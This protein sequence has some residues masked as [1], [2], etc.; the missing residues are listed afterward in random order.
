MT[1]EQLT[2]GQETALKFL[3][4]HALKRG[5]LLR[6]DWWYPTDGS[7]LRI[8]LIKVL[9]SKGLVEIEDTGH[10]PRHSQAGG[11]HRVGLYS[12]TSRFKA[13]IS[14]KHYTELKKMLPSVI[15]EHK[16]IRA[17]DFATARRLGLV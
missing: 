17:E 14:P 2:S 5:W 6:G 16:R 11:V 8:S 7:T 15:E 3:L 1:I 9:A 4:L 13:R 12:R 10:A